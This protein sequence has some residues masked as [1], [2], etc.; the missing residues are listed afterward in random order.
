MNESHMYIGAMLSLHRS[1]VLNLSQILLGTTRNN[2]LVLVSILSY[3][4]A[5]LVLPCNT[6]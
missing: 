2:Y 1:L 6:L 4:P 3:L 5:L